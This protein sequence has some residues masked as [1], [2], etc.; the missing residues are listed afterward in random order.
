MTIPC[1]LAVTFWL[2]CLFFLQLLLYCWAEGGK[3]LFEENSID[4][5]NFSLSYIRS[6]FLDLKFC[7]FNEVLV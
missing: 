5:V 7:H 3:L 6:G 4:I 2:Y 1:L